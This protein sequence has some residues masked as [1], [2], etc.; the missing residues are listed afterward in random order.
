M[1]SESAAVANIISVLLFNAC[2]SN[3]LEIVGSNFCGYHLCFN[4]SDLFASISHQNKNKPSI[5]CAVC[6][7]LGTDKLIPGNK[8][9]AINSREN[10]RGGL[11]I[12]LKG[13]IHLRTSF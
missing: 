12:T 6:L 5:G 8:H 1:N 7:A 2:T 11:K 3:G 4:L 9:V 10:S 13:S